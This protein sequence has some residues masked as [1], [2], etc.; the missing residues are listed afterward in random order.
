MKP[1]SNYKDVHVPFRVFI[2]AGHSRFVV[3]VPTTLAGRDFF[4]SYLGLM[5]DFYST[6]SAGFDLDT[7]EELNQRHYFQVYLMTE[8]LRDLYPRPFEP[9]TSISTTAAFATAANTFFDATRPGN[10]VSLGYFIDW[11]DTRYNPQDY[12]SW[13]SFVQMNAPVYYGEAYN[14]AKHNNALPVTA[15]TVSG[16]NNY[17][18]P[19]VLSEETLQYLRFRIHIAPNVQ[20]VY[21]TDRQLLAMGFTLEQIGSRSQRHQIIMIN[22]SMSR[23]QTI[24]AVDPALENIPKDRKLVLTLYPTTN[25]FVSSLF[26]FFMTKKQL[27][28]NETIETV[29]KRALAR[30]SDSSNIRIQFAYDKA[31][32]IFSFSFP[33]N[34][35]LVN[36]T[37]NVSIELAERT[38]FGL[39]TAIAHDNRKGIKIDDE[40]DVKFAENKARA[41][42]YDTSLVIVSDDNCSSNTTTG[43]NEKFMAA[44]YPTGFGTLEIPES[45]LCHDPPTMRLPSTFTGSSGFIPT[46]FKLSR[47]MDENVLENLVWKNGAFIC[48]SLRGVHPAQGV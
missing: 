22:E 12:L 42:A 26:R 30:V 9:A 27:M 36:T 2:P 19:T 40:P 41:L 11:W 14:P 5:P 35:S 28:K 48:G 4:F 33:T 1:R 46:T 38:G 18:Y 23:F 32:K 16:A 17:L 34:Q 29:V 31:T 20:T 3:P 47:F 21:S 8:C 24:T 15:R 7:E 45:A 25:H 39:V 6:Q 37:C 43:I 13:D 10:L 44:L